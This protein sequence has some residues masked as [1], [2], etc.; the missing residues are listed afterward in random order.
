MSIKCKTLYEYSYNY[1][2]KC[3]LSMDIIANTSFLSFIIASQGESTDTYLHLLF[4]D[5]MLIVEYT[6]EK[7]GL[8]TQKELMKNSHAV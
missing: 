7:Q 3:S 4:A 8:P 5:G 1:F 2:L 6:N